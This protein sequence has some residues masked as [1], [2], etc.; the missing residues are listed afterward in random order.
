[1][2]QF[3]DNHYI[4]TLLT[5]LSLALA[6]H[7][8]FD[9][10]D[11]DIERDEL[12][13]SALA[14]IDRF[15]RI[16]EWIASYQNLYSITALDCLLRLA[17]GRVFQP[18]LRDFLQY[19]RF[20][21]GENL[22]LKAF[23]CIIELGMLKDNAICK[24]FI[25]TLA[26][27]SSAYFRYYAYQI[28]GRGLAKIA[29]G[30]RKKD[31]AIQAMDG[32]I[33]EQEGS[34]ETRQTDLTRRQTIPGAVAGL[35]ADLGGN[36]KVKDALWAAVMSP[37]TNLAEVNNFLE[38]CSYLYDP[39]DKLEITLHYPRYWKAT[40]VGKAVLAF[41]KTKKVRTKKVPPLKVRVQEEPVIVPALEQ[42]PLPA[43][44][45]KLGAQQVKVETIETPKPKIS[46]RSK[47]PKAAAAPAKTPTPVPHVAPAATAIT[48]PKPAVAA[49]KPA[50]QPLKL[51]VST[52]VVQPPTPTPAPSA[53]KTS[54]SPV[55]KRKTSESPA[56]TKV[57]LAPAAPAAP[58][59]SSKVVVFKIRRDRLGKYPTGITGTKG[60]ASQQSNGAIVNSHT[61][62]RGSTPAASIKSGKAMS[63]PPRP[64]T[65]APPAKK[66]KIAKDGPAKPR[67]ATSASPAPQTS[68]GKKRKNSTASVSMEPPSKRPILKL[69]LKSI[70]K[71]AESIGEKH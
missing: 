46:F 65:G 5:G 69:K 26:M 48:T 38:L 15:R 42:P 39:I 34:T 49:P 58:A 64:A 54:T 14:E 22:R 35:K 13:K 28:F 11:E 66:Q 60:L 24:Y 23:E 8:G 50:T 61:S 21:N 17:Q 7:R 47:E 37:V 2:L 10:F 53:Q 25:Y 3:S 52:K 67:A 1:M 70:G 36:L 6:D 63:P 20:G 29:L 16:D 62:S 40:H 9:S 12:L 18:K 44:N 19:T 59:R 31:V 68:T 55:A 33:I 43:T 57:K 27:D 4:A 30:D 71:F 56:P 51:K 45:I 41:T 32:L